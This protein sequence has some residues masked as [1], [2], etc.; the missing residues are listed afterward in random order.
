L[1]LPYRAT[2]AHGQFPS[3]SW[4]LLANA[5]AR[6]DRPT[7]ALDEFVERYYATIHAFI[8]TAVRHSV[9]ADDLTQRFFEIVVL[10]GRLLARADPQKGAFRLYLKQAIR[11]FL[12]DERR[13][14]A[15]SVTPDVWP[16]AVA[17]GWN[18]LVDE[19]SCG[20]DEALL[21]AWAQSLVAMAVARLETRCR[22][23]GQA[24]HFQLF[25]QRY[26]TDRDHPPAWREV[27]EAFG[28]DEKTA[29][30]R[31]ETAVRQFRALVRQL[32]ARDIGP[33]QAIDDELHAA[34][35]V[36]C[37]QRLNPWSRAK[38][39]ACARDQTPSLSNRCDR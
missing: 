24:Q 19:S 20:P 10:S 7:T 35:A 16:D 1:G 2:R 39:I 17:G 4:V 13:R 31:A 22:A 23:N 18:G 33:E 11:N 9:D 8:A 25:A 36:L 21:Q 14:A 28:L 3:P 5:S 38:T 26:L 37:R 27:G 32:L 15:R 34:I 12:V 6:A 29:R 30:S